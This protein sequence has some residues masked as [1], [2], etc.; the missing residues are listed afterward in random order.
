MILDDLISWLRRP[1]GYMMLLAV[2]TALSIPLITA[3]EYVLK[4]I[5]LILVYTIYASSWNIL[6]YS[7]QGS[8]GH[9]T[10]FGLGAYASVLMV[11]G[12]GLLPVVTSF[13]GG[14]F[15]AFV[16]FLIGLTCVK[17]R[18]WFLAM[19]TFGFSIIVEIIVVDPLAWLTKGRFGIYSQRLVPST[20]HNYL[21]YEYYIV[22]AITILTILVMY[23]VMRSDI[24]LAF[25]AIRENELV[26]RTL[27][28]NVT[29]YKLLAFVIS[30]LF[31]GVAGALVVH[32]AMGGFV[33]EEMFHPKYSFDPLMY[34]VAGGLGT[35][36]GPVI[37]TAVIMLVW[38]LLKYTGFIGIYERYMAIGAVL[39]LIV[40]FMPKGMSYI[41]RVGMSRIYGYIKRARLSHTPR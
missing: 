9:A 2:A 23:L 34:S 33:S 38:E 11:V 4:M 6:A 17:L 16:G 8:L 10:F 3:D 19:V 22:F 20:V 21:I 29:W 24:G 5:V 28:I 31:A 40:V 32:A 27:G 1:A 39:I 25:A 12:F 26:A 13:I 7:G 36:E 37:G 30:T 35:I 14:V 18:E 41:A 15:A